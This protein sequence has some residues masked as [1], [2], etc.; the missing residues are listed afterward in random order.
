M[1]GKRMKKL[2]D[3]NQ[4][5]F[6]FIWIL[7]YLILMSLAAPLSQAIGI[8]ASGEMILGAGLCEVLIAFIFRH[9][10][11][12]HLGLCRPRKPARAFLYY[13]PLL[14]L[15]SSNLWNGV[16]INLPFADGLCYVLFML[17]AAMIEE[18]LFRGFLFQ[19]LA[20]RNRSAA[21]IITSLIFGLGH[22]VNLFNGSGMELL[23]N[24]LQIMSAVAFGFLFVFLYIQS[25]SL[26]P[27]IA[28]HAL[29]NML[30]VFGREDGLTA[31]KRLLFNLIKLAV[32]ILYIVLIQ[33]LNPQP[34]PEAQASQK[35]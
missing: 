31:E 27:S 1:K 22:L 17:S 5:A 4:S 15:A 23:L 14:I 35:P 30:S 3:K 26:I 21:V 25:G 11:A 18:I 2:Y 13:L 16:K 12:L 10:L 28:C 9:K 7:I 29:L 20:Q 34:K 6:S 19:A 8:E 32:I 33:R 24:L